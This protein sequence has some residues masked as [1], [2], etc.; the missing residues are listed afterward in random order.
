MTHDKKDSL[1]LK[2]VYKSYEQGGKDLPVLQGVDATFIQGK[3]YAI[4]GVSGSGK[5]TIM[6]ILGGLDTPTQGTVFFNDNDIAHFRPTHKDLFLNRHIGFVFQFHYLIRELSARE[7]IMLMGLIKGEQRKL[8]MHRA[9]H[10]LEMVGLT[11]KADVYPTQLSGGEQQRV[12]IARALFNKPS[13][14]LADEPTGNLDAGNAQQVVD[15]F[16]AAQQEWGMGIIICSHD[17]AV[18]K[19]MGTVYRLLNGLLVAQNV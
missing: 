6:H 5:S 14:L 15:L 12:A 8:C 2:A 16:F 7:N 18:Y 13:F 19:R 10:L 1:T 9:D 11:D 17:M 4:T 3:S